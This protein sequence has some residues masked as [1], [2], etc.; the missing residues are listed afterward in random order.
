MRSWLARLLEGSPEEW[1][2]SLSRRLWG[3]PVAA[4]DQKRTCLF[5][6]STGRS[7]TQTLAALLG[8]SP[9]VAAVHEP[10]PYL[11]ALSRRAY[12]STPTSESEA[13]FAEA[14][15]SLR[16]ERIGRAHARGRTY[17]ETS[18][19][20]TFLAAAIASAL[21]AARFL[22]VVRDPRHVVRSGMRRDW[23]A[24]HA[25]D[26]TR[27]VPVPGR[28]A[29]QGTPIDWA[30][31]TPFEKNVW[32]WA[33]TNRWILEHAPSERTTLLRAEALLA[34]E[35]AALEALFG[36]AGSSVPAS[37]RVQAVLRKRYNA[38]RSGDFPPFAQWSD[39]QREALVRIAGPVAHRLGY[40]L[41][42]D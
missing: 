3:G 22:H 2:F 26:A 6:L 30:A 13:P 21:P 32:L 34:A 40:D 23:Y 41:G 9:S 11:Y 17:A 37:T 39:D 25:A 8:Q 7:G 18:P 16:G 20:L 38:Q 27:I 4:I 10:R 31:A 5:V 33:E 24:G 29:E 15:L 36:A 14:F 1:W 35:P 19:Q 28:G 12:E 42:A